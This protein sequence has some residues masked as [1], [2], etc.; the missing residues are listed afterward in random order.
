MKKLS[1]FTGLCLF[2]SC[3]SLT[4]PYSKFEGFS[5][6]EFFYGH[7]YILAFVSVFLFSLVAMASWV[8]RSRTVSLLGLMLSLSNLFFSVFIMV[9]ITVFR[10][11]HLDFEFEYMYGIWVLLF[12]A[13]SLLIVSINDVV[14]TYKEKL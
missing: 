3:I 11:A 12:A 10:N 1:L 13:V 9:T 7:E 4:L 14:L 5:F 2:L 6:T 8:K